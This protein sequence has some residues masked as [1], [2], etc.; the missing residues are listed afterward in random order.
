MKIIVCV[1]QVPDSEGVKT[2]P[3]TGN[4]IRDGVAAI[5]N[6]FDMY[7]IEEA[8]RLKEE[9]GWQVTSLS[10]GPPASEHSLRY[11]MALGCDEAVLLSDRSFAGAD[12]LATSYSLSKGIEKIGEFDIIFV[13][14][15]TTD[16]DTG[17]VGAGIAEFLGIPVVYYVTEV[18][19]LKKGHII[20]K[21]L[22]EDRIQTLKVKTPVVLS[23]VKGVN[24][25]RLPTMREKIEAD[26]KDLTIYNA[27]DVGADFMQIGLDGSPTKVL[28]VFPPAKRKKGEIVSGSP[29]ETA[30]KLVAFLNEKKLLGDGIC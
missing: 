4:L 10:M 2:D 21:R 9:Y 14:T 26:K 13:G 1:K 28:K 17:Q 8:V 16:G 23:V 7:A 29:K 22:L 12:T 5:I 11:S 30:K 19:E 15:K 6:P 25:P 27:I 20:V 3:K 24:R 18:V